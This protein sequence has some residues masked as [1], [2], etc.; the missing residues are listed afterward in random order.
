MYE[1]IF[2]LSDVSLSSRDIDRMAAN[3]LGI[4]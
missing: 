4:E 3:V 2:R 1:P